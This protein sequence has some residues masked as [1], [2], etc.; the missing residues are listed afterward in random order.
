MSNT[1][2]IRAGNRAFCD[3]QSP[4]ERALLIEHSAGLVEL[5]DE[6]IGVAGVG[7]EE[8]HFIEVYHLLLNATTR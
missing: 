7:D 1:N 3:R 4:K 5:I 6:E 8:R 2:I